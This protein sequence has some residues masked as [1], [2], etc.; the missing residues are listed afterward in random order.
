M[1][2]LETGAFDNNEEWLQRKADD[3]EEELLKKI[4]LWGY[5]AGKANFSP[6]SYRDQTGISDLIE[7]DA[8][9]NMSFLDGWDR[10]HREYKRKINS[11][12]EKR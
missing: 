9:R 2:L 10:G 1:M 4:D 6:I 12:N 8:F 7:S 11:N 5:I 3:E